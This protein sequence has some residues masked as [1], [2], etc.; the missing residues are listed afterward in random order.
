MHFFLFEQKEKMFVY[1]KKRLKA[2]LLP[3]LMCTTEKGFWALLLCK[4]LNTKRL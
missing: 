1:I 4:V 2:E 3:T